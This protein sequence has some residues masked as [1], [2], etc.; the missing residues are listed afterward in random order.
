M[1]NPN[2]SE[3][4]PPPPHRDYNSPDARFARM[5]RFRLPILAVGLLVGV[6]FLLVHNYLVGGL[7]A[8]WAVLRTTML[9]WRIRR[10]RRRRGEWGRT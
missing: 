9:G 5:V 7:M 2:P 10:R 4:F 3:Q 1:I 8:G 6:I